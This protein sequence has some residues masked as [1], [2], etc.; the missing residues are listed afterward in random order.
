MEQQTFS[1]TGT[2]H[3]PIDVPI[4][5]N[6][7]DETCEWILQHYGQQLP[8]LSNITILLN[9][10]DAVNYSKILLLK[11]AAAKGHAALLGP[12]ITSLQTWLSDQVY[13]KPGVVNSHTRELLLVE[14][15][16]QHAHI[17]G[18]GSPWVLAESLLEL[19][20]ELT[21]WRVDLP[22]S[23]DDFINK[24]A[25][26]YGSTG[27]VSKA[28]GREALLVHTLWRALHQQLNELNL[29]DHYA[30]QLLKLGRSIQVLPPTQQLVVCGVNTPVPAEVE[31]RERLAQ[32]G[33]LA[34]LTHDMSI[35]NGGNNSPDYVQCLDLIFDYQKSNLQ[36]R[37][38]QCR[39]CFPASPI[40]PV[41]SVYA[42]SDAEDEALAI[43]L[44]VRRW[45]LEGRSRIGIIT[46]N[47]KLA[48]RVRALL[49]RAGVL[50]EDNAG[51]P[52]S[53]T[54]AATVLER[55]LETIEEDFHYRPLL[56]CLK[57]PFFLEH[58]PEYLKLVYELEQHIIIGEN[59][60]SGIERYLTHIDYRKHKLRDTLDTGDYDRLKALINTIAHAAEP[61]LPL[62]DGVV[63]DAPQ[64]LDALLESL[65]R[66]HVINAYNKDSAGLQ[67][68]SEI[69]QL[70]I[71]A[72]LAPTKLTW[73]TFRNWLGLTL[74]RF[75]F[76]IQN[77]LS[78]VTLL[79]LNTTEY[80]GFDAVI[81]AGAEQGYLPHGAKQ[82]PFFNDAV[83][84]ALGIPTRRDKQRQHYFLFRRLL[85]SVPMHQ[86]Q[87]SI[88][89]T[90]RA[91]ENNEDIIASPW[92]A[93]LQA[94][95]QLAYGTDLTD[96]HLAYLIN[97]PRARIRLDNAAL[98]Q[99]T[100]TMP[101]ATAMTAL[102][103]GTL[104]ASAYQQLIDCP[105]RFYA[106][107]CLNLAP[108]DTVKEALEKSDYGQRIHQCLEA[109][110]GDVT[111]LPGPFREKISPQNRQPAI[112][113][114]ERISH[115][116]FSR[117]IEDNFMHR[118]WL[119]RWLPLIPLYV[120]WQMAQQNSGTPVAMEIEI[121]AARLDEHT[122]IR[123][124]I[125]RID[126]SQDQLTIIDYKT[127]QI[128]SAGDV[129]SGEAVQLPFYL[130]LL[131]QQPEHELAG[132]ILQSN[133]EFSA[134]YVDLG[135]TAKVTTRLAVTNDD[136]RPLVEQNRQRLVEVMHLLRKGA[137]LPAWGDTKTCERCEMDGLCRK[138]CWADVKSGSGAGK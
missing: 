119:K 45:L 110:H 86:A 32:R 54:S 81:L 115:A 19:F 103:P 60:A 41:I 111:G 4:H 99:Q 76:K 132:K 57:S 22:D 109:F 134:Q 102:I 79:T 61:L 27:D 33:Q 14:A 46:E 74:E 116:V 69:D 101:I 50:V 113:L 25:G 38:L 106:A 125:D 58:N 85:V 120:D 135:D 114:L 17:Y 44:Q 42:A 124:R 63:H 97:N 13:I 52:L 88:L 87:G 136:L 3:K 29:V 62:S 55:W 28:L 47:R 118:G 66:L 129:M 95:H 128:P 5:K 73:T 121:K 64:F 98:P 15:L 91:R 51:W 2:Y 83:R 20:D 1:F 82:S 92:I 34:V 72:R 6:L 89:I 10:N 123:G 75:N 138:E 70:R 122:A 39:E 77:R 30:A 137:G 100:N 24:L 112:V 16:Q 36:T 117:D 35:L 104:S 84:S 108:P 40:E 48:R 49:E 65:S 43:D 133:L 90:R 9:N 53:T 68:L 8:D 37:A 67:L 71:A 7:I 80:Y 127:G 18:H 107:R 56:D 11:K 12:H 94:F 93:E 131:D 31:W 96:K 21:Q 105:Y 130:M 26:A 126:A 23:V 59:I 78:P